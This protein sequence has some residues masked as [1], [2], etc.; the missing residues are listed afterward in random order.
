MSSTTPAKKSNALQQLIYA[1]DGELTRDLLLNPGEYGLGK[2]P[3]KAKPNGTTTSVCGFC[4]T[5]CGLELHLQD[6]HAVNLTPAVDWPVNLGM[7]CPK[8]WESLTVLKSNDRATQPLL[9][10]ADG[11]LAPVS[12]DTAM[13]AFCDRFKAIQAEHGNDSIAFLSTGQ[14]ATEEMFFLGTLAKFGMGMLHGDGNTRQCMATAVVAYKEAFGFDAPPFTY[15]DFEES[16]VMVFVGSNLCIAHPIMWERVLRNPHNPKIIVIDPRRTETAVAATHHL[17]LCPK[18]DLAL[19]YTIANILIQKGWIDDD[20]IAKNT[21][22]FDAFKEAIADYTLERGAETCQLDAEGIMAVVE[23]IHEGKRVSFWWTMGVNQSHQ[24]V[25]TAQA[26][27]NLALMTGNMGRPGTGANSITGQCNAMG[28]RLYS[29]TTNLVGGHDFR[30]PEDR[31]KIAGILDIPVV[32]I[33][34]ENS[35]SYD[36]IMEG[37]RAGEIRGLWVIATNPA[38]SWIH[39]KEAHE[40]FDKLDFL[41]VQDMYHSTETAQRADLVLPAAGWG[42][43]EGTFINSERRIGL[44]KKVIPAPGEA[45]A[46]F[47]IFRLAANYWGCGEMFDKWKT[48]EDVFQSMKKCSSDQPCDITGIRD[49]RMLDDARG[50]QWPVKASESTADDWMP[51]Q[52]RRLF[53]QDGQYFH[54]DGKAKFIFETPRSP[55]EQPHDAYPLRLLTGRGTAA[56]WHTQ[57]KT[58]KSAVLRTLYSTQLL[59]DMNP[60]DATV[61]KLKPH[62]EVIVESLRGS[63]KARVN[64]VASVQ[65]GHVFLPMHNE[66]TNQL[67]FPEFDTYSRQP[68]YKNGAVRV[69]KLH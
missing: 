41:V 15:Q 68:S 65:P 69:R 3:A 4:S 37:I 24:G 7:A 55:G 17:P 35:W 63:V 66:L 58:S 8:G 44:H 32:N 11:K 5:G 48:P 52:Q 19:L 21:T 26:I 47:Q 28:S 54:A 25:R 34:T 57:T 53:E 12:W 61:L 23:A 67:T 46:D 62:D 33:P 14:I 13:R 60:E 59:V 2:V 9:K 6:G 50:I 27:I 40:T 39:Q 43:K 30:N 31:E 16:D 1:K 38:H 20:Y 51:E 64:I 18:T 22:G 56:Q 10:G 49:Y 29:N 45:L 36:R 42:E